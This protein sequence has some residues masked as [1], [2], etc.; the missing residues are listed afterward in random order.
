MS[1]MPLPLD[2]RLMQLATRALWVAGAALLL[3]AGL[4]WMLAHPVWAVQRITVHGDVAHQNPVTFRAHLALQQ[5]DPVAASFLLTDLQRL[6]T[7]FESVP[8]VRYAVVQREFPGRLRVTLTEHRAAAWW[9]QVGS[10]QLVN[11]DGEV[12]EASY[13]GS[14]ELPEIQGPREQALLVWS[15][16]GRLQQQLATLELDL[17]RL[18]LNERGNWRAQLANGAWLELGRG[19]PDEVVERTQRFADTLTQITQRYAASVASV[20]LRY[21]NGYALRLRGVATVDDTPTPVSSR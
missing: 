1:A 15:L 18:E 6:R 14:D 9:G 19:T 4:R 5:G 12:F 16:F 17:K 13:E 11:S 3:V 21:P 8:W 2:V 7:V 20:D 10:G